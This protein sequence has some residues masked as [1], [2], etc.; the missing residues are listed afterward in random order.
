MQHQTF[1]IPSSQH[2]TS[3]F[4]NLWTKYSHLRPVFFFLSGILFDILTLKRIDYWVTIVQQAWFLAFV[5]IIIALQFVNQFRTIEPH[6]LLLK[7][8]TYR[9]DILHFLFGS[10]LSAFTIFYFKSSSFFSSSLFIVF[11][12]SILVINELPKFR[13]GG[14]F[15]NLSLFTICLISYLSYLVPIAM[16]TMGWLSIN[17]SIG[18]TISVLWGFYKILRYV[19][20]ASSILRKHFVFPSVAVIISFIL[21]YWFQLIPPVPL[22]IQFVGIY[23]GVEQ[24]VGNQYALKH[25]RPF[26]KIWHNGDQNFTAQP[27]DRIYCFARIFSPTNFT[28]NVNFHWLHKHPKLGWQTMDK[29]PIQVVGGRNDGFR[30]FAYK[31]KYQTGQWRIK[32]ETNLGREIGRIDFDI[33]NAPSS[34]RKFKWDL[35]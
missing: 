6:P 1:K 21:L 3:N 11:L 31:S 18:I 33:Q 5:S 8:W 7:I 10:L 34:L 4:H 25:E 16:G 26:W 2:I 15:L 32:I 12:M 19:D 29:I 14:L 30:G 20:V 13:S 24:K 28:H 9:M 23:H 27:N 35:L 17:I 22:S